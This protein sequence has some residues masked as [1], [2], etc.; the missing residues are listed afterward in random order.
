MSSDIATQIKIET[1]QT[2]DTMLHQILNQALVAI[3]AEAGSLMTVA[4]KRGILQI[5]ARLGKPRPG[6]K[7]EPVY[8]IG[9]KG[10]VGWV[11]QNK[12]AYLCED[13]DT[14]PIFTPSLSGERNFLSVL[15]APIVYEDKVLAVINADAEEKNFFT[16]ENK[17]TLEIVA[18]IAA[19]PIAERMSV[20]DALAE[21]GVELSRLPSEGGVERVLQRIA[22]L[23]VR[24]LGADV[25]TI[26]PYVQENDEFPVEGS[27]PTI[28]PMVRD[29]RFMRRKVYPNDVP[30]TVV[31]K[32][33]PGFYPNVSEHKFLTGEVNRPDDPPRS[34]FVEREGIKSMAALLLPFRAAEDE[35]EEV[36][37]VM[38]ANYR[39]AHDFNID[40]ISALATFA[41]YAAIAILNV[42]REEKR[43]AEQMKM[44]ESISAN[45][46]HRMNNLAGIGRLNVQMLKERINSKDA[47]SHQLLDEIERQSKI[48]LE[49]AG[50]LS[51][52]Y[53]TTGKLT[54]LVP[55]DVAKIIKEEL[56]Q[57]SPIPDKITLQLKLS[58]HLP[59]VYSV[60]FQL[61]QVFYDMFSNALTALQNEEKG[62]F[63][64]S[65]TFNDQRNRVEVSISDSGSGIPDEIS[66][67]L[68]T[69][70][71]TTKQDSLG[72]GLWW[73]RTFLQATG[74][75]VI[76]KDTQVGKGTTFVVI[77][78]CKDGSLTG[79]NHLLP[80][81]ENLNEV[82]VLI[83][84]DADDWREILVRIVKTKNYSYVTVT[85]YTEALEALA[86]NKFKLVLLDIRL[87]DSDPENKDGLKLLA[88]ISKADLDTKVV[89][90]SGY[91]TEE[92][93]KT[94]KQS[95]K[96]IG[97]FDKGE[98]DLNDFYDLIRQSIDE[99]TFS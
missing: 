2:L 59:K 91:G 73:C 56:A 57:I 70:G 9:D 39:T 67:K 68:F 63:T 53:R 78:P 13:I 50:R 29:P 40:E 44:V 24:S 33:K 26:Y 82:D 36:V 87:D 95:A 38:F 51:R 60:E 88:E 19:S 74:G 18:Q 30:W 52:P 16:E 42:R 90:I 65:T 96:F 11:V 35:T 32:R 7:T 54:E 25:V 97:F 48:L 34:R 80:S 20:L 46:A 86:K 76:L 69:P 4:N 8:R 43:R 99:T 71:V 37:G 23:A 72:I 41:D 94:A 1:S 12:R 3:G 47:F 83:I 84:D 21:A 77:I 75:D 27:G 15:A 49:L 92:D 79:E 31:K 45:F 66:A 28:A 64:I 6:R 62:F 58:P 14:D 17:K 22:E 93:I 98:I 55:V 81:N 85:N 10:I 89:I 61:R 5:K